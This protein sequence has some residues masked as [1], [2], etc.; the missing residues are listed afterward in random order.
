MLG[1]RPQGLLGREVEMTRPLDDLAVGVVR[2]LS[3]EWWPADETF[4]HDRSHGPPVAGEVVT[5]TGEDF[6][7]DVVGSTHGGVSELPTRLAPG[8]DLVA[9]ADCELD[10]IEGDGL[11]V[12]GDGFRA[13]VGHELLVVGGCMLSLEACRQAEIGEFNVTATVEEDVVGFDVAVERISEKHA[14]GIRIRIH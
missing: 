1:L 14:G 5:P 12:R 6:G 8:V 9:V 11:S 10:L 2:L 3:A 7:G 4:E 13:C